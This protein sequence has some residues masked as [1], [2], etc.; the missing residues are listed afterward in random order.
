MKQ[1]GSMML[2]AV[3]VLPVFLGLVFFL[4]QSTFVWTA[5]QMALYAA[6]CGTRVALVYNPDD[7]A[8]DGGVVKR[9]V[10]MVLGWISFSHKGNSPIRIP[11]QTGD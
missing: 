2:E 1:R 9:A 7:Y 6:Y 10:C 5:H 8:G 11:S 3:L 4:I